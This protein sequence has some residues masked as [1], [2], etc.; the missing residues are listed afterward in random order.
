MKI[1][2]VML[3]ISVAQAFEFGK[4]TTFVHQDP[5]FRSFHPEK[6]NATLTGQPD[7]LIIQLPPKRAAKFLAK[8]CLVILPNGKQ[9]ELHFSPI[10]KELEGYWLA[11]FKLA[12]GVSPEA[13]HY[14]YSLSV[15]IDGKIFRF[16]HE[17]NYS[18]KEIDGMSSRF[19]QVD[20]AW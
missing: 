10:G 5:R 1:L 4:D 8:E 17:L 20:L 13:G 12:K 14:K 7:G 9:K 16:T 15:E 11:Q 6:A 3:L 19:K 2:I 18:F